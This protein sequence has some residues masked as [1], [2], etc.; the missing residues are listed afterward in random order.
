MFGDQGFQLVHLHAVS[1]D[2]C[3]D[4]LRAV[5]AKA[6]DSG[7]KSGA[8]HNDLVTGAD[9]GLAQQVQAL[10]AAGGNY[11]LFRRQVFDTFGF[12]ERGQLLAQRVV[13]FSGTVLQRGSCL[14]GQ[15]GVDGFTNAFHIKHGRV[16]EAARKTDDAGLAQQLE[17]FADGRRFYVV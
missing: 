7:Q 14:F 6:L 17:E 3:A 16:R 1:V 2:R 10:L 8:F 12:H 15:R 11:H 4:Q 13:A 9:H 5:E